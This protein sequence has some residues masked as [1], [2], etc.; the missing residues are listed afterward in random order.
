MCAVEV[1]KYLGLWNCIGEGMVYDCYYMKILWVF[2]D[3]KIF[4]FFNRSEFELHCN[5]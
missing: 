5:S 3:R 4:N 2:V 1:I